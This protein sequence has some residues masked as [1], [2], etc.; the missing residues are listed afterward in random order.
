MT[1]VEHYIKPQHSMITMQAV[2]ANQTKPWYGVRDS[3]QRRRIQNK[4]ARRSRRKRLA[5]NIDRGKQTTSGIGQ[6]ST[7]GLASIPDSSSSSA[8]TTTVVESEPRRGQKPD[9]GTTINNA[10]VPAIERSP[11]TGLQCAA[12]HLPSKPEASLVTSVPL[13]VYTALFQNGEMMGL[14]CGFIVPY[15]SPKQG[16]HVPASLQPTA[17]QLTTFHVPWIDRFPFRK[18][19]DNF[20]G[21]TGI[22]DE[23]EF[24]RD[25]FTMDSLSIRPG[26]LGYDPASWT[27]GR[28]FGKKWGYLWY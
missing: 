4:L 1:S 28:E 26:G 3:A 20:I 7:L 23:D 8:S 13:T 12:F 24:L 9:E 2:E 18:M 10:L 19:R 27:M 6:P 25:L 16:P 17:L 15:K 22:I 21:L 11:L 14:K 5:E